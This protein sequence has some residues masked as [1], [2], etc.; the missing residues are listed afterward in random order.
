MEALTRAEGKD[1]ASRTLQELSEVPAETLLERY[2]NQGGSGPHVAFDQVDAASG[3]T[4]MLV[5]IATADPKRDTLLLVAQVQ[6]PFAP[7]AG[8][9]G[10]LLS[11]G[12]GLRWVAPVQETVRLPLA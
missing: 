2:G 4:Y 9:T 12:R 3:K 8:R 11:R 10:R 6:P 7:P 1:I 5:V